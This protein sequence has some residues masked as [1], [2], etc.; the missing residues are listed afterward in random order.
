VS[1][2]ALVD[3]V[4]TQVTAPLDIQALTST[5]RDGDFLIAKAAYSLRSLGTRQ[6]TVAATGDT[7][8]RANG[9]YVCQVRRPSDD[10]LKSFTAAEVT[11]GTLL[12]FV[13]EEVTLLDATD[14]ST[15]FPSGVS[16]FGSDSDISK[17][18]GN[19]IGGSDNTYLAEILNPSGS[20][21]IRATVDTNIFAGD[22]VTC[23]A[24]I[25]LPTSN[26]STGVELKTNGLSTN[27]HHIQITKGSWQTVSVTDSASSS[28]IQFRIQDLIDVNN[29]DVSTSGEK[30]YVRR[31][32]VAV[33][34]SDGFVKT[35]YDQS[36][37]TQAGDTATGNHATQATAAS[38]P[39]IVDAGALN[40]SGGLEFDSTDDFFA[41]TNTVSFEN[42]P[43]TMFSVQDSQPN[44]NHHTLGCDDSRGIGVSGSTT[45]Y[46]FTGS[47]ATLTFSSSVTGLNLYSVLHDGTTNSD[48]ITANRNGV[49]NSSSSG[50]GMSQANSSSQWKNIGVRANTNDFFHG[51]IKEIIVYN[52]DQ[53]DNRTAIEANMGE[54]YSISGIPAFDNSVNGFVET[55]YDQSGNGNDIVQATAANQ[56]K[57][58]D[59]GTLLNELVFDG[60]NHFLR[61]L[62][63]FD[64]FGAN[65]LGLFMVVNPSSTSGN[66][67][68][69]NT[70]V[71]SPGIEF[72]LNVTP[73]LYYK[74]SGGNGTNGASQSASLSAGTEVIYTN[75]VDRDTDQTVDAFKN[76]SSV[77]TSNPPDLTG[78]GSVNSAELTIGSNNAGGNPYNGKTKEIIIYA[79]NQEANRTALETNINGHYSI[80]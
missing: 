74:D 30:I 26:I 54:H 17:S 68:F 66:P 71:G 76:G 20:I 63:D 10:A 9:K 67:R 27:T 2:G 55:W 47:S 31:F 77:T 59:A 57:I 1:S 60:S 35:W 40:T 61:T 16:S 32:K 56:P 42:L 72:I 12:S 80:F 24:E 29:A 73:R 65:S 79:S 38:Q 51:T 46:F 28:S 58:V 19:S 69:L 44:H 48:N 45:Q 52:T 23:S 53:T 43:L 49:A 8:A 15:G 36:V 50:S 5:G 75:L 39:K 70:R 7:V 18:F 64:A 11:D 21:A 22:T 37:T 6:A 4:N 25:F 78:V 14:F 3:F 34:S 62:N 41:L 13:T 33:K